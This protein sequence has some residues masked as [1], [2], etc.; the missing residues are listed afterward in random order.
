[1]KKIVKLLLLIGWMILI[2]ILSSENGND[3]S[4]TSGLFSIIIHNILNILFKGNIIDQRQF[5][6][7][8]MPIIRKIAHFSEYLVLGVLSYVNMMEY[9]KDNTHLKALLFS[10]LYAIS[11]EIHQLFVPSRNGSIFDVL[12]DTAGAISGI[13]ICH[14][15]FRKWKRLS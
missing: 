11:D 3:S 5:L 10:C 13:L 4:N 8:Y 15:I 14:F 2:F 12:I 1:M 7:R 6:I 9:F